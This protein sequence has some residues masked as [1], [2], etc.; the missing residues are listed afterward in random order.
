MSKIQRHCPEGW[1]SNSPIGGGQKRITPKITNRKCVIYDSI[2]KDSESLLNYHITGNR[3]L[4]HM[5]RYLV[6]TMIEIG[7]KKFSLK[8]FEELLTIP[9]ENVQIYKAPANGLILEKID[10]E[11]N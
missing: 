6:G 8:K 11:K 1:Q 7:K 3:F 5:V 10:Y 4:H 2:W 9:K